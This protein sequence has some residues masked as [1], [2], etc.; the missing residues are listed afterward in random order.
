MCCIYMEHMHG[1][2]GRVFIPGVAPYLHVRK[3]VAEDYR[4]KRAELLLPQ[5]GANFTETLER[6][7]AAGWGGGGGVQIFLTQYNRQETIWQTGSKL[8]ILIL[9]GG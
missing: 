4:P 9:F 2:H 1:P 5:R 8:F 3:E 6:L 7:R